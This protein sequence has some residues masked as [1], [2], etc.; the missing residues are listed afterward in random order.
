[1]ILSDLQGRGTIHGIVRIGGGGGV[2]DYD[3]LT[4]RPSINNHVVTGSK[5]GHDYDLANQE[6]VLIKELNPTITPGVNYPRLEHIKDKDDQIYK[7]K[8]PE[9]TGGIA[10]LVPQVIN[11]T[12]KVLSDTGN[13][14]LPGGGIQVDLLYKAPD[15]SGATITPGVQTQYEDSKDAT[16]YIFLVINFCDPTDAALFGSTIIMDI[17]E[18]I[19]YC[20]YSQRVIEFKC[21]RYNFETLISNAENDG[22][23]PRIYEIYGIK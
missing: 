22:Y 7:V 2:T 15:Y 13:W 20:G 23:K 5:T 9:F 8:Y 18:P 14:I 6:D 3:D 21:N 16:D 12:G 1:M 4:N 11:P 17:S 10:G 19:Y